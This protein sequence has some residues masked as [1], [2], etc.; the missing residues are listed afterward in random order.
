MVVD[1]ELDSVKQHVGFGRRKAA[2]GR[3]GVFL[4]VL[5]CCSLIINSATLTPSPAP[6]PTFF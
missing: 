5:E 4:F 1:S 6:L 2:E 3:E